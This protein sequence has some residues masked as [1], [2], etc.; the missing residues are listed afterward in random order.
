MSEHEPY[1]GDEPKPEQELEQ[2]IDP[3]GLIPERHNKFATAKAGHTQEWTVKFDNMIYAGE[4]FVTLIKDEEN[5]D[6]IVSMHNAALAAEEQK[7]LAK[8][9]EATLQLAD[10]REKFIEREKTFRKVQVEWAE[11]YRTATEQ[12]AAEEKVADHLRGKYNEVSKLLS[13][14]QEQLADEQAMIAHICAAY[15]PISQQEAII[16]A[17]KHKDTSCLDAYVAEKTQQLRR[18]QKALVDALKY[19]RAKI[20]SHNETITHR[21]EAATIAIDAALAKIKEGNGN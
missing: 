13:K 19:V 4:I 16:D 3:C 15:D 7:G 2:E 1:C 12:L 21:V 18:T 20:R 5:R 9:R 11:K 6:R 17:R 10:E 14:V 8:W